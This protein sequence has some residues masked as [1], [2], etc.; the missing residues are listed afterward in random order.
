MKILINN[1]SECALRIVRAAKQ[2]GHSTVGVYAKGDEHQL[3]LRDVDE[4]V[5][6]GDAPA[7]ESYLNIDRVLSAA[8]ITQATAIHPGYGFLSESHIFA[9]AVQDAGLIWIGPPA[10]SMRYIADKNAGRLLAQSY[11]MTT[12][13]GSPPTKDIL[14]LKRFAETIGFPV[15]L[16]AVHGGGGKGMR[17]IHHASSWDKMYHICAQEAHR[18]YNSDIFIVESY[19]HAPKHI[20]VQVLVTPDGTV[21]ILGYR[22]C[23]VQYNHQKIVEESFFPEQHGIAVDTLVCQIKDMLSAIQ[24]RGLG[25]M[26]YLFTNHTWHFIEMNMRMQVEHPVTECQ[27]GHDLVRAHLR[28][29]AG[30]NVSMPPQTTCHAIECRINLRSFT[31][32]TLVKELRLP[33]GCNV[34]VDTALYAGYTVT[35]H[36]DAMLA[37]IICYDVDRYNALQRMIVALSEVTLTGIDTNIDHLKAIL[38]NPNFQTGTHHTQMLFD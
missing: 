25:T 8:R 28:V 24:Y 36:Y 23:S 19:L 16:K 6:I 10:E 1:R 11:G 12:A 35:H 29:S 13:I 2:L 38:H 15:L 7:K 32:G 22:D 5:C 31:H 9:Q 26:E 4:S 30:E 17:A 14:Q 34:R 37:K 20:E 3:H 27:T 21:H 33:G 18:A